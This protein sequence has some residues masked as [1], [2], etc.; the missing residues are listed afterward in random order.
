MGEEVIFEETVAK[1]SP[2]WPNLERA[3]NPM[4]LR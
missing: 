2:H 1:D 3:I 4:Q